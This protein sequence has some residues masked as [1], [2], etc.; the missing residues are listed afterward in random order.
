M[1][2]N[3]TKF[4][5]LHTL[6]ILALGL[7]SF[8]AH[9]QKQPMERISGNVITTD[10]NPAEFIN[11]TLKGTFYGTTSDS[12][13]NFSFN[14]PAGDYTMVVFSITCHSKEFPVSIKKGGPNRF[15]NIPVVE[16]TKQLEAVVVT[17]QFI[18]QSLRN[19][20]Y[21]VK[22]I[23][24]AR[25][26]QKGALD[27]QSLLNT[28][29][30]IR[31][32]NDVALGETQFELMGMG[33]SNI[34]VLVDGVPMV[35]R[36]ENKQSLSQIDINNVDRIEIVEGPMSVIYG[37]DAL[38]GVINIITKKPSLAADKEK[39]TFRASVQEETAGDEYE[40]FDGKGFHRENL[41]VSWS[42]KSG[43]YAKL[44]GTRNSGGGWKGDAQGRQIAW[45]AKDQYMA[46]AMVGFGSENLDL[47]YKFDYMNEDILKHYNGTEIQPHKVTDEKFLSDRFTHQLQGEWKINNR[48]K[49]NA[50]ASYQNLERRTR[51]IDIDL[52]SGDQALSENPGSQDTSR[53]NTAFARATATWR[54]TPKL[55]A[56]MGADFQWTKAS[57]DRIKGEPSLS[58]GA[59]YLSAEWNATTWLNIRPGLRSEFNSVYD[60]PPVIPSLQTKFAINEHM[61][62]RL[63]YGYGF[64]A[65]ELRQL[66]FSYYNINH[67]IVGNE[68]LKAEHSNNYMASFTWRILHSGEI[69]LT[70]TAS[71]FFNTFRDQISTVIID[72]SSSP[73]KITYGN[74]ENAKTT[75]G[76]LENSLAWKNLSAG[77]SLSFIGRYNTL[78]DNP[79]YKGADIPD[80]KFSPELSANLSYI[81]EKSGTGLNLYYKYNHKD[82]SYYASGSD[83]ELRGLEGYHWADFS[84]S[85]KIGKYVTLSAGIK[86]L[87]DVTYVE[88]TAGGG[89]GSTGTSSLVGCGRSFFI[90]A[91]FALTK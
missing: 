50:A 26:E 78:K 69:R 38:A 35:D 71:G 34:K 80:F 51:T 28:E 84:A 42:G 46:D 49:L 67:D 10:G 66:Y 23:D 1:N 32:E 45:P 33:G 24:N 70:T 91:S 57:G 89:M 31:M 63:S 9:A 13:G 44:G 52:N 3:P 83:V 82:L 62:L 27:I 88:N 79:A 58:N 36:G 76:T 55:M 6:L 81:F 37:T 68:N 5:S 17:G 21:K 4:R 30:G 48:V 85:Q 25:I 41:Q 87:F 16:D 14:A 19:S 43:L 39:W 56:Y 65:P 2:T 75:G 60:A 29:I 40:P 7:L 54:I 86:N 47:W 73:M 72:Q 11:V 77:L 22:V 15:D 18:P 61:D 90:G 59:V 53:I 12:N 8:P 20:V 64:K 74:L